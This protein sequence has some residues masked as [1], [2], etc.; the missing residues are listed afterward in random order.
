MKT[1]NLIVPL[2]GIVLSAMVSLY[3]APVSA[4]DVSI[5]QESNLASGIGTCLKAEGSRDGA[6]VVSGKCPSE[7]SELTWVRNGNMIV[8]QG[9]GKCLDVSRKDGNVLLWSCHGGKNQQWSVDGY[10]LKNDSSNKCLDIARSS[11]KDGANVMTWACS[12]NANQ[13]WQAFEEFQT[14]TFPENLDP[15][16]K[17]EEIVYLPNAYGS[18]SV[19]IDCLVSGADD[20]ETSNRIDVS[21]YNSAD[22]KVGGIYKNGIS[23]CH[24]ANDKWTIGKSEEAAYVIVSTNGDNG[25]LMDQVLM[26]RDGE[27]VRTHGGNDSRGWCLSTDNNDHNRGNF[28]GHSVDSKCPS[29]RRFNY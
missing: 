23:T 7:S 29:Q 18:Q 1:R 22:K 8:H 19:H 5:S 6:N 9:S 21:W 28:K 16:R 25:Y 12:G 11:K 3:A 20:E 17:K 10:G 13:A 26:Y 24:G 27:L 14:I 4:S 2:G 15:R